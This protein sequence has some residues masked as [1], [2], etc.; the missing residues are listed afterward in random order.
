MWAQK[1]N[2]RP[3]DRARSINM[4]QH[5]CLRKHHLASRAFVFL[6]QVQ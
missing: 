3:H 5:K 4:G 6:Q 1:N 2:S